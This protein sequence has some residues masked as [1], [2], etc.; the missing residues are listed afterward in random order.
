MCRLPSQ[1]KYT[2]RYPFIGNS[3][4]FDTFNLARHLSCKNRS[5]SQDDN[6]ARV[7][8]QTSTVAVRS[9]RLCCSLA[10]QAPTVSMTE[11]EPLI[12]D[13]CI[14]GSLNLAMR[15]NWP[16]AGVI[17]QLQIESSSPSGRALVQTATTSLSKR[18]TVLIFN[19][20]H[21]SGKY[22]Y[23]LL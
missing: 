20:L 5:Y 11:G 2:N 1:D 15:S 4:S 6:V 12:T 13:L 10:G 17:T 14:T 22:M 18:R 23:H 3:L 9:T 7:T 21:H 19:S 16:F 8:I